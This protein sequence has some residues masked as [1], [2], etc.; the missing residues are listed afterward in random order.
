MKSWHV[1]QRYI[2]NLPELSEWTL[3]RIAAVLYVLLDQ[4]QK[5]LREHRVTPPPKQ[6]SER[7][8]EAAMT[9]VKYF[10]KQKDILSKISELRLFYAGQCA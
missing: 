6:I 5:L 1:A 9:L 10:G 3:L 2:S 7:T 8:F 4:L